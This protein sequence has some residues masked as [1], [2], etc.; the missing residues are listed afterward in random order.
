MRTIIVEEHFA[1][2]GYVKGP[3][4]AFLESLAQRGRGDVMEYLLDVGD[5]R[6]AAMD[7]AGID[8]QVIS[9]NSPGVEQAE[10]AE[11]IASAKESNDYLAE[12]IKK[13]PTRFAGLAAVPTSAP[14]E[15]VKEL[16]RAI[17]QLGFKGLLVNGHIGGRYLDDQFFWPI[18]E[19]ADAM[20]IAIYVHP[21][22]PPK[23]VVEASYDG[24]SPAVVSL[25]SGAGW[26]WHI[27]TSIHIIRIILGGVFDRFPKLQFAIG[28]L[29]EGIPF[30]LPR[31]NRN[32]T[33]ALTKL[34]RPIGEYL[35]QNLHYTFGGFNFPGTFMNLLLEID[36]SRIMFS[37]D[38]PFGSMAAAR[39]FLEQI[40]VSPENKERIA[41]GNAEALFKL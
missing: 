41:H 39:A 15:A 24:F 11:A 28:H 22:I 17:N 38:Y 30:M 35:R 10:P 13:H 23:P 25:L 21:T 3:G 37:A 18:L 6:I 40:P 9:L 14:D 36:P 2:P 29:G 31:M 7:A 16:D 19:A 33:P 4:K 26:G 8:M 5:Q 20:N 27:E 1:S 32:M 12:A 34:E